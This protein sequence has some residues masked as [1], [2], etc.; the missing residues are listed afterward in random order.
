[1]DKRIIYQNEDGGVSIIAP[2]QKYVDLYGIQAIAIKD[3]PSGVP[4]KIID[5]TDLPVDKSERDQWTVDIATL[6][7]GVGG[8]SSEFGG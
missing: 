3:V 4:F 7:D 2:S 1:M 5:V 6:T 8:A